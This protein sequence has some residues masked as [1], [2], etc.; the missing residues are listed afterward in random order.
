[1]RVGQIVRRSPSSSRLV[2]GC[3]TARWVAALLIL[4]ASPVGTVLGRSS[5]AT[6]PL[7]FTPSA[8][9]RVEEAR[10]RGNFGNKTGLRVDGGQGPDVRSYLRFR[11]TSVTGPVGRATLRLYVPP[12]GGTTDG[13]E[14]HRA[15][16]DWKERGVT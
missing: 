5:V 12:G 15:R 10:P 13:P 9:A 7:V 6:S 16:N 4:V 11:V 1:M 2:R 3:S 14:I 8:D